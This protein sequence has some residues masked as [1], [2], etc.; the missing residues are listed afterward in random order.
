V[1]VNLLE[2]AGKYAVP[3]P[4]VYIRLA[5]HPTGVKVAIGD[6]GP[7]IA[8]HERALVFQKFYRG[9]GTLARDGGMG[10]G[11]TICQAVVNAHGSAL[12][13]GVSEWGGALFEFTLPKESRPAS[14]DPLA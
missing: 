1:L 5:H 2:N 13:V 3:E 4:A 14:R 8:P 6:N 9:E 10:L 7:G 11:L 12:Q